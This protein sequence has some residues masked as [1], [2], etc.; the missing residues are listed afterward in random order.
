MRET[1][2]ATREKRKEQEQAN[3]R[4]RHSANLKR[5]MEISSTQFYFNRF[6]NSLNTQAIVIKTGDLQ[7]F[8]A[9]GVNT[10]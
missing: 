10:N 3:E 8:H 1:S 4:S 2:R 5:W 7:Q 6:S 9:N